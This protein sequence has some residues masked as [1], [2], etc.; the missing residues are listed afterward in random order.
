[1]AVETYETQA[2]TTREG[3][4]NLSVKTRASD[5]DVV[6]TVQVRP[7]LPAAETDPNGWPKDYF[8]NV[9]GS[10][11]ELRR[12]PQGEFEDRQPLGE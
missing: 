11:P 6:V 1:M 4:L 10:M 2:H 9:A 7:I 3:V 5:L 8:D 12:W